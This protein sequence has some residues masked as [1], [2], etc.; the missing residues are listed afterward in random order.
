MSEGPSRVTKSVHCIVT[1]VSSSSRITVSISPSQVKK[2]GI[3][4]HVSNME[5]GSL[6]EI[7]FDASDLSDAL[8]YIKD[9]DE[10]KRVAESGNKYLQVPEVKE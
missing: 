8:T 1:P 2:R 9:S 3:V 4:F 5:S 10:F 6:D 7:V